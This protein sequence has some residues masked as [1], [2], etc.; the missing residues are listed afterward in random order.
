MWQEDGENGSGEIAEGSGVAEQ[1]LR[2]PDWG[3]KTSTA[4]QSSS[5]L[6]PWGSQESEHSD[7]GSG[8]N[9]PVINKPLPA[10]SPGQS[11]SIHLLYIPD[12]V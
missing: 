3:D 1:I 4:L 6:W 8:D 12:N 9:S 5:Y 11:G 7:E 10:P 2:K